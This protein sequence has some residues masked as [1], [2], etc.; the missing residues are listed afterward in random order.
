MYATVTFMESP[1]VNWTPLLRISGADY[2]LES[3]RVL[4]GKIIFRKM[5]TWHIEA[6]CQVTTLKIFW[7]TTFVT[8]CWNPFELYKLHYLSFKGVMVKKKG[9]DNNYASVPNK[10]RIGDM[11]HNFFFIY[12]IERYYLFQRFYKMSR[13]FNHRAKCEKFPSLDNKFIFIILSIRR[14]F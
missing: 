14:F 12:I 9:C 10:V 5:V 6:K 8:F 4:K 1:R 2:V 11:N 3:K 7:N 13:F